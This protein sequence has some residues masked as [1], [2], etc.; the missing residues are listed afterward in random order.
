MA[1]SGK[2]KKIVQRVLLLGSP[3]AG[4][5]SLSLVLA[6]E[7]DL[8][9]YHLDDLYWGQG[10][11]RPNSEDWDN[12]YKAIVDKESWIIDGNYQSSVPDRLKRAQAV[13]LVTAPVVVCLWRAIR[14][15]MR[16]R[17]GQFSE[18]PQAVRTEAE[19]GVRVAATRDFSRLLKLILFFPKRELRELAVVISNGPDLEIAIVGGTSWLD[20]K[21]A[22][23]ARKRFGRV[24]PVLTADTMVDWLK[25]RPLR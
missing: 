16:I 25:N 4:K 17:S 22:D 3:G 11:S 14:R 1:Q 23:L 12:L 8:P 5:S 19:V 13:I 7:L 2:E 18:L 15:A 24:I 6:A 9:L 21:S 10:W 20:R